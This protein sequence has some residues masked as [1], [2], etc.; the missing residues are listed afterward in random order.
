MPMKPKSKPARSAKSKP[1]MTPARKPADGKRPPYVG[2][3]VGEAAKAPRGRKKKIDD[4]PD[5]L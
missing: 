3:A 4:Y 1:A 2:F 5:N